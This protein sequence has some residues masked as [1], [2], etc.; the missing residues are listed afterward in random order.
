[1]ILEMKSLN[2]Y[3]YFLDPE[4]RNHQFLYQLNNRKNI[5]INTFGK[6][7]KLVL[8]SLK[9]KSIKKF[10]NNYCFD[11]KKVIFNIIKKLETK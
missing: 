1:M 7:Q 9:E 4:S 8:K 2:Y 5:C 11:Y 3:S 6:F 10:N